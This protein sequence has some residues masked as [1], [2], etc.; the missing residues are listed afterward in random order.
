MTHMTTWPYKVGFGFLSFSTFSCA[1]LLYVLNVELEN[2]F[3]QFVNV[4]L[5]KDKIKIVF[6]F[7]EMIKLGLI[8]TFLLVQWMRS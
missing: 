2:D 8:L 5:T 7:S 1:Y 3:D 4:W 6:I